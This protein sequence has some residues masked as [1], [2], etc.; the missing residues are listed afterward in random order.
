MVLTKIL[1]VILSLEL[2][3]NGVTTNDY[4]S[5]MGD[6]PFL[7]NKYTFCMFNSLNAKVATI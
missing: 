3:V 6:K 7:A 1:S 5:N 2:L 4:F